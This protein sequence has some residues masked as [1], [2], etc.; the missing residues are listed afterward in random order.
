MNAEYSL[1][2]AAYGL[3]RECAER[4]LAD[5]VIEW[6]G[7]QTGIALCLLISLQSD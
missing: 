3:S 1:L 5:G 7:L 6:D 4:T 2:W